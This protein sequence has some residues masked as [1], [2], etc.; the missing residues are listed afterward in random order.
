[1]VRTTTPIHECI[2]YEPTFHPAT[3]QPKMTMEE[4]LKVGGKVP[5]TNA[6]PT[7][8]PTCSSRG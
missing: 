2:E 1:M 7:P 3:V 8:R 6:R 5:A 4:F